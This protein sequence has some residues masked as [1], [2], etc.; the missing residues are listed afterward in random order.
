M[1]PKWVRLLL[2]LGPRLFE[3]K[4]RFTQLHLTHAFS[5]CALRSRVPTFS[6]E[7]KK[8]ICIIYVR[9]YVC[10]IWARLCSAVS[11]CCILPVT[12][13]SSGGSS[14]LGISVGSVT[15]LQAHTTHD[16]HK[17]TGV[18]FSNTRGSLLNN[19]THL[20][21]CKMCVLNARDTGTG[22]V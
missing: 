17:D 16:T 4:R 3:A 13:C 21:T 22:N 10:T 8:D 7:R 14:R 11:L 6:I 18:G 20:H 1:K 15:T 9:V 19:Q 2:R 5:L 12:V